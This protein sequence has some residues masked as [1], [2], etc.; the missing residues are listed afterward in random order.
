VSSQSKC[1]RVEKVIF[2]KTETIRPGRAVYSIAPAC[3]RF[4]PEILLVLA[5]SVRAV[6]AYY[7]DLHADEVYDLFAARMIM[8]HGIPIFPSGMLWP[9]GGFLTYLEAPFVGLAGALSHWGRAP[10]VIVSSLSVWALYWFGREMFGRTVA[11]A[12]AIAWAFDPDAVLWG[13]YARQYSLHP[14]L[15]FATLYF[16]RR[17]AQLGCA[18][19]SGLGAASAFVVTLWVQP[20]TIFFVPAFVIAYLIWMQRIEPRAF[21]LSAVIALSGT[22]AV[23][24][25]VSLGDPGLLESA[26][27]EGGSIVFP[28]LATQGLW[29]LLQRYSHFFT[30]FPH[31]TTLL[32]VAFVSAAVAAWSLAASFLLSSQT[33]DSRRRDVLSLSGFVFFAVAGLSF[34]RYGQPGY[35]L[36]LLGPLFLLGAQGLNA[37]ARR[38]PVTP[39]ENQ[40]IRTGHLRNAFAVVLIALLMLP[41]MKELRR[42][43]FSGAGDGQMDAY[44]YIG[45]NWQPGDAMLNANITAWVVAAD[46]DPHFYYLCV[47]GCG[48]GLRRKGDAYVNRFI[49][50]PQIRTAE[51]VG[52]ILDTHQRVWFAVKQSDWENDQRFPSAIRNIITDRMSVVFE[53]NVATVFYG[54]NNRMNEKR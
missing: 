17:A 54:P 27:A 18:Q 24:S 4:F 30:A 32:I 19:W 7:A 25:Y 47:D 22:V 2:V 49:G 14:L 45:R 44:L 50:S 5:F 34:F 41:A 1:A 12:G 6:T 42:N 40:P 35:A 16:V 43:T 33:F 31:R 8:D 39:R 10:S 37:F 29:S 23:W 13:A 36:A 38:L 52:N 46:R 21:F 48:L 26:S 53:E 11:L 15:L 3:A 51:E 28:P 9:A 20:P